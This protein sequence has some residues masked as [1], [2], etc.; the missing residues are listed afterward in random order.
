MLDFRKSK[1]WELNPGP[2]NVSFEDFTPQTTKIKFEIG[3]VLPLGVEPRTNTS[4]D[5]IWLGAS[6]TNN[7]KSNLLQMPRVTLCFRVAP[8]KSLAECDLLVTTGNDGGDR[9]TR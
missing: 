4:R 5:P 7:Y 2:S 6:T 1:L 8:K 3:L 9:Y